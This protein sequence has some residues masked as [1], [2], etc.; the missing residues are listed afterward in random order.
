MSHDVMFLAIVYLLAAM[1]AVPIAKR[2]GLGSVL[3]YLFAGIIIGPFFLNV[4]GDSQDILHA[5]EFGVV[6]MLF[7]IGM[8]LEPQ[9]LWTMRS[10]IIGIGGLQVTLTTIAIGGLTYFFV[11][12]TME[13][14]M[15]K[16]IVV[17]LTL[18]LSSTAIVLQSLREK[19]LSKS[20]LGD[21][22]FS[23]L[24]FQDMAVIPILA[25][26]PILAA[27]ESTDSDGTFLMNFLQIVGA[28]AFTILAGLFLV[29]PFFRWLAISRSR[30]IFTTATLFLVVGV[31]YLMEAVGLSPALGAFLAGVVLAESE[32]KHELEIAIDPFKGLMMG[33]FFVSVGATM[34]F[35]ILLNHALFVAVCVI[36]LIF[37]KSSVLYLLSIIFKFPQRLKWSFSL[38]LA[39]GGEFAFV[40][41]SFA[42][43]LMLLTDEIYGLINIIVAISMLATPL[44][45]IVD[46]KV[47]Q[48]FYQPKDDRQTTD[49]D[50]V[51]REAEENRVVIAGF[52]RFGQVVGRFLKYNGTNCTILDLDPGQIDIVRKIGFKVFYGDATRLELLHAAHVE[53]AEIFIVAVDDKEV[54]NHIVDVVQKH[55]PHLKILVRAIDRRHHYELLEKKVDYIKMET[56]N[57][58]LDV[59]SKALAR[60]G[61]SNYQ[62]YKNAQLFQQYDSSQMAEMASHWE[63]K[64]S[65]FVRE[66]EKN[67]A[68]EELL[69][70]D[71]REESHDSADKFWRSETPSKEQNR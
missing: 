4:A 71:L 53:N 9:K 29:R 31:S 55:F 39:Q 33:I 24:L 52:G 45:M 22:S 6:M 27:T 38:N 50:E 65:Y 68:L 54:S 11:F 17:G 67:D 69:D 13:E 14:A 34:D 5:S 7:M 62:A 42:L 64:K 57:S 44:L 12:N 63:E 70:H 30:E 48:P 1:I 16:A 60:L 35:S 59:G 10:S 51:K 56:F 49:I 58:A 2:L 3:G 41:T 61:F 37:S 25:L 40:L 36:G 46:E 26:F 21:Y 19:G 8:E 66:R 47:I 32:Y 28:I 15:D 23:V 43:S 20:P 18:A